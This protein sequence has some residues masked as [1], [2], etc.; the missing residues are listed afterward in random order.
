LQS[1]NGSTFG[2]GVGV[3]VAV[4]VGVGV[5][6]GVAAAAGLVTATPLFQINFLPDFT[7]VKVLPDATDLTPALLHESPALTAACDDVN[8]MDKRR[9]NKVTYVI[10][11][12]NTVIR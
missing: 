9:A 8:G 6:L 2:V 1:S 7:H 10:F 11:R 3:G 4:G 5:A 12:L